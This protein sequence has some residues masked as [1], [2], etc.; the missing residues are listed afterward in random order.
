MGICHAHFR[1]SL[2]N[3]SYTLTFHPDF[4]LA[5]ET[6]EPFFTFVDK[7]DSFELEQVC[8]PVSEEVLWTF[9]IWGSCSR[10]THGSSYIEYMRKL[11]QTP[12]CMLQ[13]WQ[14]TFC[15]NDKVIDYIHIV[16]IMYPFSTGY[17]V[18]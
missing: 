15:Q 2:Y 3:Y 5:I 17:T 8:V 11:L 7:R 12:L 16:I 9:P 6:I 13:L 4:R 1:A 14:N 18:V 10:F